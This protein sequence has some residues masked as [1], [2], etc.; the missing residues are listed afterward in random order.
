MEWHDNALP[1]FWSDLIGDLRDEVYRLRALVEM[2]R[3]DENEMDVAL[4]EEVK[5]KNAQIASMKLKIDSAVYVALL[6]V[7]GLMA[8]KMFFQ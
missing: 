4:Q 3:S 8:G 2:P 7:L 5:E 6:F 1:E